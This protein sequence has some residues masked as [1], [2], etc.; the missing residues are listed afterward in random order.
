MPPS[1]WGI[2]TGVASATIAVIDSGADSTHPDLSSKLAAGW[3]FVNGTS[4]TADDYG[5]GT[6]VAG[7][8]AAA[9]NNGIGIAGVSWNNMIMPLVALDST[10][11][12]SYSNIA[13]AIH[14]A[15]HWARIINISL[16][17]ASGSSTLQ[18]AVNYAWGKGAVI[19][20]APM[21]NSSSTHTIQPPA[22]MS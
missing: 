19:F 12:A 16:G 13:S 21:N 22:P 7:V 11:S 6:A 2:T 1:A 20:A 14:A 9:T 3:N 18:N 5:H 4:N 10:G 15:D 8:A 17:G